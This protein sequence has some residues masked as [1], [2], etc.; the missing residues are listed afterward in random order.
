MLKERRKEGWKKATWL[1]GKRCFRK[2]KNQAVNSVAK[3]YDF[4]EARNSGI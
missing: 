4:E 1:M 2:E 3:L